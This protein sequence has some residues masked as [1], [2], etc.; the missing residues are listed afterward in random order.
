M[1]III[2]QWWHG[3]PLSIVVKS[4][5]FKLIFFFQRTGTASALGRK[6][7]EIKHWVGISVFSDSLIW[8]G[9]YLQC[10]FSFPMTKEGLSHMAHGPHATNYPSRSAAVTHLSP[11]EA[12]A[13]PHMSPETKPPPPLPLPPAQ[14]GHTSI[15]NRQGSHRFWMTH[16]PLAWSSSPTFQLRRTNQNK[17]ETQFTSNF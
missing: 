10:V 11:A 6:K 12:V 15:A 13:L 3:P 16:S 2:V 8:W 5:L 17:A 4:V 14:P 7:V 1:L 9:F